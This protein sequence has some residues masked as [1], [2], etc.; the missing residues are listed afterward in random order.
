MVMGQRK[1][2]MVVAPWLYARNLRYDPIKDLVAVAHVA[3]TPVVIVTGVNSR[4]KTLADVVTAAKAAPD[5]IYL[6][7]AGQRH[8]DSP[9]R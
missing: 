6:W 3:Y 4:F 8:H 5:Q 9:G 1:D 7:L 2:S